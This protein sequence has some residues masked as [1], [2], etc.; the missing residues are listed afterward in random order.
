MFALVTIVSSLVYMYTLV[1]ML[2]DPH[3]IRFSCYITL[4]TFFMLVL[5]SSDNLVQLFLGWE[6]VGL[7]S[8]LLINF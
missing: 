4:F 8:Y 2:G 6:G 1:Y 3:L 5:V 7:V